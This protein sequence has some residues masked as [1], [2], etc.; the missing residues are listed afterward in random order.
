MELYRKISIAIILT[1]L[2]ALFIN[3]SHMIAEGFSVNKII[4]HPNVGV[5]GFAIPLVGMA[6]IPG[7]NMKKVSQNIQLLLFF[8]FGVI[9]IFDS[10][11]SYYGLGLMTLFT[12]IG[13][14]YKF[15]HNYTV[16]KVVVII[17]IIFLTALLSAAQLG[18]P[19]AAVNTISFLLFSFTVIGLVYWEEISDHISREA[20]LKQELSA[21]HP[22]VQNQE[23]MINRLKKTKGV[24]EFIDLSKC[25]LTK[26]EFRIIRLLVEY[27]CSNKELGERLYIS[28]NTAKTHVR[29]IFR[30][31]G[32]EN[33]WQLIDV[34]RMYVMENS[35]DLV[36]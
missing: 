36:G 23:K 24:G 6:F 7:K 34:C 10:Y 18:R 26:R 20:D 22:I 3:V 25:K 33:R 8:V 5:L 13:L 17:L 31:V 30:K 1:I 4:L 2:I 11:E 27:S 35:T 15:W 21:L 12:I 9:G 28:E 29:N 19:T 32:V 16:P 14:K